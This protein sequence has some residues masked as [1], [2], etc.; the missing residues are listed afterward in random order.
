M[1]GCQALV[2]D[3]QRRAA[4]LQR[5]QERLERD[6]LRLGD[7]WCVRVTCWEGSLVPET[8]QVIMI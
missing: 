7:C 4:E 2:Q 5:Q 6:I 3:W 1:V 8:A